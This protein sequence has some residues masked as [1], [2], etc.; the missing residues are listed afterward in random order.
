MLYGL[1]MVYGLWSMVSMGGALMRCEPALG[2]L[3]LALNPAPETRI[4]EDKA[5][6]KITTGI[7][8]NVKD[9]YTTPVRVLPT[10]VTPGNYQPR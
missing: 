2:P 1:S 10:P 3:I 6:R 7:K 5:R 4:F 9:T 8:A